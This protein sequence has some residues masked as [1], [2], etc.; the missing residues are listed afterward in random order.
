MAT[1]LLS[2]AGNILRVSNELRFGH[3]TYTLGAFRIASTAYQYWP[4]WSRVFLTP[5][6]NQDGNKQGHLV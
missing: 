5:L 1:A 2:S 4:T 3:F 6:L